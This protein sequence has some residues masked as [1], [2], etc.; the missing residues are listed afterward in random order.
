MITIFHCC[1]LIMKCLLWY[2]AHKLT[3]SL[4][5]KI[6][7][8][9]PNTKCS[10]SV[11]L[12][13]GSKMHQK[14]S[15]EKLKIGYEIASNFTW[16]SFYRWHICSISGNKITKKHSKTSTFQIVSSTS[17]FHKAATSSPSKNYLEGSHSLLLL[18]FLCIC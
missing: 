12:T 7:S 1:S 10:V 11:F 16:K 6:S 14:S 9:K 5:A 4:M 3:F 17:F 2:V 13:S 18:L 15:F 8:S